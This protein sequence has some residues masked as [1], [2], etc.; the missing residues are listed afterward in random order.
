MIE[1]MVHVWLIHVAC[2]LG[3]AYLASFGAEVLGLIYGMRL[4]GCA[5]GSGQDMEFQFE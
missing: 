2:I 3:P 5:L 1:V 4:V